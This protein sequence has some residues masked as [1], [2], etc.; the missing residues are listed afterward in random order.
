[1]TPEEEHEFYGRP[2]DQVPQGPSDC[3]RGDPNGN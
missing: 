2:E 3:S 1:M